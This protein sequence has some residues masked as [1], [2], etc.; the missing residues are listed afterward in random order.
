[1]GMVTFYVILSLLRLFIGR[2]CAN[3]ELKMKM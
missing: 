1:M 3:F 2:K